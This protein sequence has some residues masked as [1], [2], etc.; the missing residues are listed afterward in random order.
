MRGAEHGAPWHARR[1]SELRVDSGESD[2]ER[3]RT[4]CLQ[5]VRILR[6]NVWHLFL[7]SWTRLSSGSVGL[8]ELRRQVAHV[9]DDG[10]R[11]VGH[12]GLRRFVTEGNPG[13]AMRHC[14]M[15]MAFG[16]IPVGDIGHFQCPFR[17]PIFQELQ[18]NCIVKTVFG[19][20]T[21]VPAVARSVKWNTTPL[22][23][24]RELSSGCKDPAQR[25]KMK[26]VLKEKALVRVP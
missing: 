19:V 3:L 10:L 9:I 20:A 1:G 15:V 4:R 16:W 8:S 26:V 25:L 7:P 12:D 2:V 17:K 6:E 5:L 22:A 23:R 18:T 24:R 21:K 14:L 13:A 11:S